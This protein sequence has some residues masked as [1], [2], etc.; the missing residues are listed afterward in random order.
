MSNL[1]EDQI[2]LIVSGVLKLGRSLRARRPADS[3]SMSALS[4][5]ATLNE[6]GPMPAARLAEKVRLQ[7][8]SLTRLIQD[9]E[10]KGL[11]ARSAGVEDK[12]TLLISL[13]QAGYEAFAYDIRA[14]HA[15]LT[16][17]MS[18]KLNGDEEVLLLMAAEVMS[19][20]AAPADID[21]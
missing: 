8:Q 9:M 12:R 7:P 14:R 4:L 21:D 11:I 13:T 1:S 19:K 17:A 2:A 16:Q 6:N 3:V 10:E 5:M 18:E 20:L 15:W